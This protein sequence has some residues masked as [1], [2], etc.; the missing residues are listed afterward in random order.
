MGP[1]VLPASD[2]QGETRTQFAERKEKRRGPERHFYS[3]TDTH[4]LAPDPSSATHGLPQVRAYFNVFLHPFVMGQK[5]KGGHE[6]VAVAA[7]RRGMDGGEEISIK[8]ALNRVCGHENTMFYRQRISCAPLAITLCLLL[9]FCLAS[10]GIK[11]S[12]AEV[13]PPCRFCPVSSTCGSGPG[14]YNIHNVTVITGCNCNNNNSNN[15]DNS[16]AIIHSKSNL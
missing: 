2:E 16:D 14:M 5:E 9:F 12:K 15:S 7:A 8:G 4:A 11:F 13:S 10:I 3:R 6:S 1:A